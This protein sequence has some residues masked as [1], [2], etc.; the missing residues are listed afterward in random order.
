MIHLNW[1]CIIIGADTLMN[2]VYKMK[3]ASLEKNKLIKIKYKNLPKI[4][5]DECLVK[6]KFSGICSSDIQR[7]FFKGAYYYPLI[8]GH[9]FSGI[10]HKVGKKVKNFKEG[11]K[12]GVF[13]LL[14]CFKC[15]QC[16]IEKYVRCEKY[17][18]YGSRNDGGFSEYVS[19]KNW[20]LISSKK[21]D[22]FQLSILEPFAVC[23]HAIKLLNIK[24]NKEGSI[25]IIGSGYLGLI[26][27][28]IL[29]KIYNHKKVFQID[30]NKFKL[31]FST[32]NNKKNFLIKG[33]KEFSKFS[34]NNKFNIVIEA[35]GN[36]E[37]VSNSIDLTA[38]GGKC[39]WMGNIDKDLYLSKKKVSSIL[40]KEIQ[41]IGSWNSDYKTTNTKD[42]WKNSVKFLSSNKFNLKKFIT[43]FI[44]LDAL[45]RTLN[46][47][48]LHKS[49][50]KKLNYVK[51]IVKL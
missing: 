17:K 15:K 48:Y 9:E 13:P 7:G 37:M 45:P 34:K 46:K 11:D 43:K 29:K 40:R 32:K 14:P 20:N 8:M 36:H 33:N 23:L 25:C 41:I 18:Y 49:G 2:K 5:N 30:R 31:K 3:V 28:E 50:T 44:K 6:V 26:I 35:T 4:K 51:Y 10:I 24:K 38:E 47:M 1:N 19:V 22:L 12:V 42:D 21:L 16:A 27:S 39:L